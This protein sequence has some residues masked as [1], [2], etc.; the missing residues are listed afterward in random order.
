M[1]SFKLILSSLRYY[2]RTQLGVLLGVVV[3]TAVLVGAM[4]VGDSVRQSLRDMAL[5]RLG[6][7]YFAMAPHERFFRTAL[8]DRLENALDVPTA[9]VMMLP[10]TGQN[11]KTG[12]R[13]S[14][15]SVL[16]V[17]RDFWAMMWPPSLP[18]NE[19][20]A[21]PA[22]DRVILSANLAKA[23]NVKQGDEV[24]LRVSKPS[25]LPRDAPLTRTDIADISLAL[26]VKVEWVLTDETANPGR[27]S[28]QASQ[29]PPM[30]AFVNLAWLQ[31]QLKLEEQANLLLVGANKGQPADLA[32]A[33]AAIEAQWQLKDVNIELKQIA[34]QGMYE[35]R[36]SRIFLDASLELAAIEAGKQEK[37]DVLGV[38]TY[39]VN[40]F[41][42]GE[43]RVPYSMATALK[44]LY[45]P[46]DDSPNDA[47]TKSN[48][49]AQTV[50]WSDLI[51][52]AAAKGA[53]ARPA[54]PVV[55]ASPIVISDWLASD[56]RVN[57][58]DKITLKYFVVGPMRELVEKT[59]EPFEVERIVPLEGAAADPSFMPDF[60]DM[61]DENTTFSQWKPGF[62]M[63][64]AIRKIDDEYW[65]KHRGTPKAFITLDAGQELWQ[66]RFGE[67]T[68]IRYPAAGV[69][70]AKLAAAIRER[71]APASLGL[72][73]I[74]VREDALAASSQGF[75]FAQLFLGF[76]FFLIVAALLLTGLLFVFAIEQRSTEVGTLLAVGFRPQR[77]RRILMG[78][79]LLLAMLG[80]AVGTGLGIAYTRVLLLG[81]TT[82]W[83]DAISTSSLQFHANTSTLI[84]GFGASVFV[85]M[86][87]IGLV[88]RKQGKTPARVLLSGGGIGGD[89]ATTGKRKGRLALVLGLIF[90]LG[91][92]AL[93]AAVGIGR[94]TSNA[95]AF[96]GGGSM[97]LMAGFAFCFAL[98]SRLAV[99]ADASKPSSVGVH[100]SL[101]SL[102][103]RNA[104][105]R[106]GRSLAT[107]GLLA[108][109]SFLVIAIGAFWLDSGEN[110]HDSK[111]GTGGF[112]L[113][114]E[115]TL[116]VL[117]DLNSD[118]GL[119]KFA[120]DRADLPG[121][122]FISMRVRDGDDASCLNLNRAQNPKLVGVNVNQIADRNPFTFAA[123]GQSR[124]ELS[125]WR[126]LLDGCSSDESKEENIVWAIGDAN[127]ITYGLGLGLGD[128]L[129]YT[130]ESGQPFKV[131]IVATLSNSILQG[132]L[133]IDEA[134]FNKRFPSV[135]GYRAF[136]I[137]APWDKV[138]ATRKALSEA[139][140][141]V[142]IE[143]T[144]TM[145]RLAAFNAVQNT[146]LGIFQALG[147]LGLLLGS[148]G[149]GIVVLRNVLERRRELSLLS[150][151]GF[152]HG[153][154]Q[155]LV[156]REHWLLL[157]MG[158]FVGVVSAAIAVLP[159]L[160]SPGAR[161]PYVLLASI[162]G[163]V[164]ISGLLWTW[165]ASRIALRGP[166]LAALREE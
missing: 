69:D 164:V 94:G 150:A 75:D 47:R 1:T 123:H 100:L 83:R 165:L 52:T 51:P 35:L 125:A 126:C 84:I 95:G 2:W 31:K 17:D 141:D 21:V 64:R 54:N 109:G 65:A 12:D 85:A 147:G 59:S 58:G 151:V 132:S 22:E 73:M 139:L 27:F 135:S 131:K 146:Y 33:N 28:L 161:V 7:T 134:Q 91:A 25:L 106:R 111:S 80:A 71:L 103:I 67:L 66:N 143:L 148:I 57:V 160:L 99:R 6:E 86:F 87:T 43:R 81:L 15:M 82:I 92:L 114:G 124:S 138:E 40:E 5:A 157:A 29:I 108:C 16:G 48:P 118:K 53:P 120:L 68:A 159:A 122:S 144:L 116:P 104:A 26:R 14:R 13:V 97:L 163:G 93:L 3:A 154:L 153:K 10:G 38:L 18:E 72:S 140:G 24:L 37:V 55:P 121:V 136:L 89:L 96:F 32:K 137:D 110:A 133:F 128:T 79:G 44:V 152:T 23:L 63:T 166:I 30:N 115:S 34:E 119:D 142:G 113:Y 9:S 156:Q 107:I 42:A 90:L 102:S 78:E 158:L 11:Q 4:V 101:T 155:S 70:Q 145:Q 127:T 98:L 49:I 8:K 41:D 39:L 50:K 162:L 20:P 77:V 36:T 60:P 88:L 117:T 19:R 129:D 112:A 105:R 56:L 74:P 130:D 76:S 62:T 61:P 149:L 45:S 46:K